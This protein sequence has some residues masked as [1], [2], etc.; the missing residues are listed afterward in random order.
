MP[1]L[2]RAFRDFGHSPPAASRG[3]LTLLKRDTPMK[4]ALILIAF[5]LAII[6]GSAAEAVETHQAVLCATTNH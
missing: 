5:A 2:K 6:A 3:K 1:R 4:N